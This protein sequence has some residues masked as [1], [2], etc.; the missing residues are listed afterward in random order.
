MFLKAAV[1]KLKVNE[2]QYIALFVVSGSIK[3][4]S[5]IDFVNIYLILIFFA[6]VFSSIRPF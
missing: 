3:K 6:I 5:L 4:L 1:F 2:S